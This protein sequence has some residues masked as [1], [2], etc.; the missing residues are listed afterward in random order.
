[1]KRDFCITT[2]DAILRQTEKR[3]KACNLG[4]DLIYYDH[5]FNTKLEESISIILAKDKAQ[6]KLIIKD[7]EWWIYEDV[8]KVIVYPKRKKNNKIDVSTPAKF[9]DWII[10]HYEIK[11]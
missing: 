10:N 6:Q 5:D 8:E 9:I 2:L 3:N 7:V 11:L 4:I 1:M